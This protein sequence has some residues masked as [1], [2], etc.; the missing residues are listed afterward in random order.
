M[1]ITG[2]SAIIQ[3]QSS[4][5]DQSS[6]SDSEGHSGAG[7]KATSKCSNTLE[8]QV[9]DAEH[10]HRRQLPQFREDIENK[11]RFLNV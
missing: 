7:R 6:K 1:R 10:G 8:Y 5:L 4:S 9:L 2:K 3:K 11:R